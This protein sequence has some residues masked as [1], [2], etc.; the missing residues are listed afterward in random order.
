MYFEATGAFSSKTAEK[1]GFENVYE[2][3]LSEWKWNRV[4]G[5]PKYFHKSELPHG[6]WSSWVLKLK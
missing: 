5:N 6:L 1:C 3:K 4:E 2:I